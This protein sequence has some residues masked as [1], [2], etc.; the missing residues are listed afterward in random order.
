M[1]TLPAPTIW[2]TKNPSGETVW[3]VEATI[4]FENGRPKRTRRTAK[5]KQ[6]A[7]ELQREFLKLQS[8]GQ[9]LQVSHQTVYEYGL[10]WARVVKRGRVK[11]ST[12]TNYEQRI[13]TNIGPFIG[14]IAITEL[15][16]T[17]IEQWMQFMKTEGL[18]VNTVNGARRILFGI[19]KHA[20]RAGI[21][22]RNP[23]SLTD[24][25][26]KDQSEKTRVRPPWTKQEVLKAF[27]ASKNTEWDLFLRLAIL[28]GLRRG[29]ILGLSYSEIDFE[30]GFLTINGTLKEQRILDDAGKGKITLVKDSPKTQSSRRALGLSWPI[31]ESLYRHLELTEFR[32]TQ[33]TEW[34]ETDWVFKSS[35]GTVWHPSNCYKKW[36]K[37][38]K[39]NGLRYIRIHDLRHTTGHL[40]LEEGLS[41]GSLSE[42]LGHS[43]LETT[44]NIYASNVAKLSIEFPAQFAES[45]LPMD[46]QLRDELNAQREDR[47]NG[48]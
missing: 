14:N 20:E 35:K 1:R 41:L 44:K 36:Q 16:S 5:T 38:C 10:H 11:P 23:V 46:E 22:F 13:R 34:K 12:A 33:A 8:M 25:L 19:M 42:T 47:R 6:M 18:S 37:F 40:A 3:K 30:K 43:R 9:I 21:I 24:S 39:D 4:A 48:Q 31:I 26:S 7:K 32:K 15:T 17:D 2:Q 28:Q 27:N 29:E 45:L